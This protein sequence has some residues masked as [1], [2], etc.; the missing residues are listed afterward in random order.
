MKSKIQVLNAER[1]FNPSIFNAK[2]ENVLDAAILKHQ[3]KKLIHHLKVFPKY[4]QLSKLV[5]NCKIHI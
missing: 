5:E 2:N 3:L 4:F 1:W